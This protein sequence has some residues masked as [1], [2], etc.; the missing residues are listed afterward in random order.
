MFVTKI[1]FWKRLIV[2]IY[3]VSDFK[4]GQIKDRQNLAGEFGEGAK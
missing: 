4:L 3:T 1:S 2:H